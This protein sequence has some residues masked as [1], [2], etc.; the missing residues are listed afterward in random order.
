MI[1]DGGENGIQ[2]KGKVSSSDSIKIRGNVEVGENI[3]TSEKITIYSLKQNVLGVGGKVSTS[4]GCT[5][6]GDLIVE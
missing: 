3:K 4:G 2:I 5:I 6:E 1:V